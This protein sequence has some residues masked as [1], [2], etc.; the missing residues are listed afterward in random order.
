[1]KTV[2]IIGGLGPETTTKFYLEIV[3]TF[4]NR[5]EDSYPSILIDSIP[6]PR[7]LEKECIVKAQNE[8]KCISFLVQAAKN[9]EAGGADFIVL[10]CNSLHKF[11]KE[12]RAAVKIPV[13]N[14]VE[15][16][17]NFLKSK[18]I[19]RVGI[20]ATGITI[21]SKIYET[22]LNNAGIGEIVPDDKDQQKLGQLIYNLAIGNYSESEKEALDYIIDKIAQKH[23]QAIILACTDLQ[24]LAPKHQEIKV[25]DTMKILVDA[26]VR[27][28][29]N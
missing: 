4:S 8:E 11:I 5:G 22:E 29:A 20:L 14:I 9:L 12:I 23:V 24:L 26:T 15:E 10:A 6:L 17:V 25:F 18:N 27:E 3:A 2:G 13:L 1:M 19:D 7:A 16:T 21:N 28:M